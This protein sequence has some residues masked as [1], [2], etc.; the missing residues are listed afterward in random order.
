MGLKGIQQAAAVLT[1]F[2][3]VLYSP[4]LKLQGL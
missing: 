3:L 1:R 4:A 2:G